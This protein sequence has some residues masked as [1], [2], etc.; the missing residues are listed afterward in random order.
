MLLTL[1]NGLGYDSSH[2]LLDPRR[3]APPREGGGT[4]AL[5][6]FRRPMMKRLVIALL[7]VLASTRIAFVAAAA[8][9]AA[10]ATQPSNLEKE[11]ARLK[12]RVAALETQVNEL[13]ARIARQQR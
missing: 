9:P 10:P 4:H 3:S 13:E 7:S 1:R 12:E 2:R 11:N 6:T 5:A 8:P